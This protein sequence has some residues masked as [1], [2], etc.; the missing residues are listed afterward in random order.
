MEE[1]WNQLKFGLRLGEHPKI[2][3]T[4]TPKPSKFLKA[5]QDNPTT[6]TTRGST[7]DNAANLVW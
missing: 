4:T 3:A 2:V 5:L 6:I 1:A 7:F